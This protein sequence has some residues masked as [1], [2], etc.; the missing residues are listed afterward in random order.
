MAIPPIPFQEL[1]SQSWQS[2]Y[3]QLQ[4]TELQSPNGTALQMA[5]GMAKDYFADKLRLA[6][7]A[8]LPG[9][10]PTDAL[11]QIG[12]ERNFVEGISETDVAFAARLVSAWSVW[13]YGGTPLGLLQALSGLGYSDV[14][15]AQPL[16]GKLFTLSGTTLVSS[17]EPNGV[18]SSSWLAYPYSPLRQ[19]VWSSFD[20][21]FV[22][23]LPSSWGSGSTLP[24]A[25]S[26]EMNRI[27]RVIQ[28]WKPAHSV[29]NSIAVLV[30]AGAFGYPV[31]QTWGDATTWGGDSVTRYTP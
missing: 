22:N 21:L 7:K 2:W 9:L 1:T 15:I 8:R 20:V 17:V 29:C 12:A 27:R 13:P 5:M 4:I 24:A 16:A 18:W 25:T 19:Y 14:V 28:N 26:D 30:S 11:A 23:P 6:L 10:A 31:A 3:Q